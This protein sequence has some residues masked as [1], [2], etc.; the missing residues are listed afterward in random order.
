MKSRSY[1]FKEVFVFNNFI[2]IFVSVNCGNP[3]SPNYTDLT[4]SS[5]TY[6]STAS[7]ACEDKYDLEYGSL[8]PITCQA[9]G[10]W[11][12]INASCIWGGK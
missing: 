3:T 8:D 10:L 12:P 5:T 4:V 11:Q 9:D 2:F 6:G 7:I 1:H